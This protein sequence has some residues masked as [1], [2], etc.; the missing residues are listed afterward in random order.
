MGNGFGFSGKK[1]EGISYTGKMKR[2]NALF[3]TRE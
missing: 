1:Y 3:L 2:A